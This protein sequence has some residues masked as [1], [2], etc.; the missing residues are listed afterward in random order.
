MRRFLC[1]FAWVGSSAA[2]AAAVSGCG[3]APPAPTASQK[4]MVA[5]VPPKANGCARQN[6]G[7]GPARYSAN[8]HQGGTVALATFK[9]AT[10]AYVAD[11]D[12]RAIHTIDVDEREELARTPLHGAPAQVLVLADGRVAVSLRNTNQIE[13]LEPAADPSTPMVSLCTR[14]VPA[15]P[16]GLA[17]THDDENLL[18]TSGWGHSLTALDTDQ[19][20]TAY[21]VDLPREP[22]AVLVDDTGTRAFVSHAIGTKLS[23]VDIAK[24]PHDVRAVDLAVIQASPSATKN[25]KPRGGSQGYALASFVPGGPGG[26]PEQPKVNGA[27]PKP[28]APVPIP[29]GRIFVPM[30]TVQPGDPNVR[31]QAYYGDTRDGVPKEAPIV[32]V[33]DEGAER[34]MTRGLL[35]VGNQMSGEC[36]L[37]RAAATRSSTGTL[38]VTCVGANAL[39][40][41]DTRGSDPIRLERRRWAVPAGPTGIAIDDAK[42]RAVVWSQY[43]GTLSVVDLGE[44]RRAVETVAVWSAPPPEVA[45]I[46]AGRQLFHMTDDLRIAND[47]VSCASCHPD[48]R[49]DAFTWSTPEGPRQT[50]MLAG[51]AKNTEPY[52]W[53]GKHGDLKTYFGNTFSRLGGS[54]ITGAELDALAA[55]V[56]RM[57]GPPQHASTAPDLQEGED[58]FY[59]AS[60]GC[61]GCHV[62]GDAVDKHT[63]DVGSKAVADTD[64]KFDTPS[65][66]FIRGTAPYFH[67]GRYK[68]LQEV[69]NATDDDMGHTLQLTSHQRQALTDYLE[70]L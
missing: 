38:F 9:K 46:Q 32:S 10:I 48:G 64:T 20:A 15:E 54:G 30:V 8:N 4:S 70:S 55:F 67:D 26:E 36:L 61:A 33:V 14:D 66:R 13:V 60:L 29:K 12:S 68:N 65:L 7:I 51:R 62:S 34:S 27:A 22:R 40:E 45:E 28:V 17:S 43:D 3:A 57:P 44:E 59:N 50:I 5:V 19:F 42:S 58:L 11:E 24:S 53:Q 25:D 37:P 1:M 41:L 31:S 39:L 47:G 49:D 16:I 23:I 35:S 52:G 18:V 56:E 63:H 21:A 69:L 2:L 6:A